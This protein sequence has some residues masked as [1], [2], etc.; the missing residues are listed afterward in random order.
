MNIYL[1]FALLAAFLFGLQYTLEKITSKY[2]LK[3]R[4]ALLFYF[5]IAF[6]PFALL[7][8]LFT[9]IY[10]P[11]S[12]WNFIWLHSIVF[13]IGSFLFFTAIF[14]T[15]VSVFAPIFQIQTV[16][17]AILAF[18]FL[19]ERFP[20]FKYVW[21]GLSI[22]GAMLV[23]YD[24]KVKFKGFFQKTTLLVLASTLFYALSDICA[25]FALKEM[26]FWNF[27]FWATFTNVVLVLPIIPFAK[28]EL[29]IS[30]KQFSPILLVDGLGFF[31]YTAL[32][33][34]YETNLTLSNT[35]AL[36]SAP[37]AF[38]IAVIAS[39]ASPEFLEQHPLRVYLIRFLGV[40][41]TLIGASQILLK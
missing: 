5:Y 13:V 4:S 11:S 14:E 7:L 3:T 9:Q 17:L 35:I 36:L 31:G 6:I 8:P 18:L 24:E 30:F 29:K 26:N 41:L 40:V 10:F 27:T 33:K 22:L 32:L 20:L 34:A 2:A 28:S 16:L 23:A 12:G 25:G 1:L 21:V 37:I 19:K 38:F 39:R 15:D